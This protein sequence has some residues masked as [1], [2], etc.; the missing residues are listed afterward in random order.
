MVPRWVGFAVVGLDWV[1]VE[2]RGI[3]VTVVVGPEELV[4]RDHAGRPWGRA[5]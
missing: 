3:I 2:R 4:E 1:L 5:R